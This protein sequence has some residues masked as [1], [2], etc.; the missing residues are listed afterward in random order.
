MTRAFF[1]FFLLSFSLHLQASLIPG[2][3]LVSTESDPDSFIQHCYNAINGDYCEASI[4]LAIS[5]PDTLLLQR[6]YS[7]RLPLAGWLLFPQAFSC[8]ARTLKAKNALSAG[9]IV[10]G[11]ML[12]R[13]S[14]PA[15]SSHIRMENIN[16]E[17][18]VPLKIVLEKEGIG[19][20]N[21]YAGEMSGRIIIK[22]T[23][24]YLRE[25]SCELTLGDGTR[26]PVMN[27]LDRMPQPTL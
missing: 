10:P 22:T 8:W 1:F 12:S 24:L 9:I 5:A 19:M 7:N 27:Q 18:K 15:Q 17:T 11:P 2:S 16:G 20:V 4:D 14:A 3:C 23:G 26:R 21:T 6:Y 13:E 25:N